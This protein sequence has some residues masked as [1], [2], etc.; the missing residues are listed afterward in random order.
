MEIEQRE[1]MPG[2]VNRGGDIERGVDVCDTYIPLYAPIGGR[3]EDVIISISNWSN[4]LFTCLSKN[5]ALASE[6]LQ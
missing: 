6:L 1:C 3:E 5:H 2:R 4:L